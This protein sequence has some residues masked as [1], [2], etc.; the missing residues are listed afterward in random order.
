ML[1]SIF[2]MILCVAGGAAKI[3]VQFQ[4]KTLKKS[5]GV[6]LLQSTL[7]SNILTVCRNISL[8][9]T[10][11]IFYGDCNIVYVAQ[12]TVSVNA[13]LVW[14]HQLITQYVCHLL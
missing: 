3:R 11:G 10:W 8:Y 6:T 1:Y 5:S 2:M 4:G 7:Q 13:Q 14:M 9:D 12:F